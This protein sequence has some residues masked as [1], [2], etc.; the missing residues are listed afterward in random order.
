MTH[1]DVK[2]L[3]ERRFVDGEL[4]TLE[5]QALRVHLR[6]CA[7]CR[8]LYDRYAEAES[9]FEGDPNAPSTAQLARMLTQGPKLPVRRRS[10]RAV[11]GGLI[12]ASLAAAAAAVLYRAPEPVTTG[13]QDGFVSRGGPSEG[14]AWIRI[15]TKRDGQVSAAHEAISAGDGLLFSYSVERGA[16]HRYL[17]IAGR[18]AK[19]RVH[20]FHPAFAQPEDDPQ[21]IGIKAGVADVELP[22]AVYVDL[23]A[24]PLEV[25]GIFT[26]EPLHIAQVDG[27]LEAEGHWPAG[28][29]ACVV[30]EVSR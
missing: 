7:D 11:F 16:P 30:L 12:A 3:L 20:W 17:A 6:R 5:E 1:E 29:R 24:G 8:A 22:E 13:P 27:P 26:E 19:G 14:G 21:S 18:D 9:A 15:F 10:R 2:V 4:S 25:C 23:A 28:H